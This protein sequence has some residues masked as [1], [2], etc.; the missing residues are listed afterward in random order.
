MAR[1]RKRQ[2]ASEGKRT[3]KHVRRNGK[4]YEYMEYSFV[5][6][7]WA[8][9]KWPDLRLP[10]RTSKLFPLDRTLDGEAW[11][12]ESLRAVHAGTWMPEKLK[13]A[14]EKR[15]GITFREFATDW[16]EHRKKTDGSDLKETSRQKI[17]ES[18]DLYLL[19]Y[20]GDMALV[21]ITPKDVQDWFDS[22]TTARP[23]ADLSN[24]RAHV[25]RHLQTMLRSAATE[26]IDNEGHT[27][28][29]ISPCRIRVGKPPVKH[30]PVRPTRDQLD[31][32][33]D[34]LP[35]YVR[36]VARVCD[37]TGLR[38]GEALGLC[39]KH[40]DIK[41]MKIHVRQQV[42]RVRNAKTG[43]YETV[44]TTPKTVSSVADVPMTQALADALADWIDSH[45]ITDPDAPLFTSKRTGRMLSPQNYRNQFAD[46]RLKVPG[47]ETMR[48]HDLRKDCLSRMAE[49]GAT[50]PE[51]MRQGRHVSMEVASRYQVTG[52]G[53]MNDVMARMND[54]ETGQAGTS[55]SAAGSDATADGPGR[56]AD[57]NDAAALA[58]AS[59]G[60]SLDARVTVLR[61]LDTT[62]RAAIVAALP[63][64]IRAVT[65]EALL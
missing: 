36:M 15:A 8:F 19:P 63:D 35:E 61:E 40:I 7:L 32:L 51:I 60:L 34:A 56:D 57:D 39:L 6:P 4:T 3:A 25:Y 55:A 59:A 11:L 24:R 31:A 41:G 13:Q 45:G 14:K 10:E 2:R 48:P 12:N 1:P 50:V 43:R 38:E 9:S 52:E 20:F 65:L 30:T 49:M 29:P 64:A 53:H 26:P 46:A 22:F 17:R 21:D 23:D 16:V 58:G 27:L 33:L 62:K 47:L 5:T 28:I 42:Q 44:I 37:S 18:L 54:Y